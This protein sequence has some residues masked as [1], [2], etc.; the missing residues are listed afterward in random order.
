MRKRRKLL[1]QLYPSYLIIIV[2]SLT[3]MALYTSRTLRVAGQESVVESL[4]VQA[5]IVQQLVA[6]RL[7]PE[8][9]TE[10]DALLKQLGRKISTRITVA[11]PSGL[12]LGDSQEDPAKM[13]NYAVRPEVKEALAGKTGNC[14]QIQLHRECEHGLC[15]GSCN[16]RRAAG[17]NCQDGDSGQCNAVNTVYHL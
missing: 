5:D 1:W 3:A 7:S 14:H 9:A 4:K 13:D 15:G 12:P 16:D 2:V 6:G 17:W 10:I 8:R 11:M